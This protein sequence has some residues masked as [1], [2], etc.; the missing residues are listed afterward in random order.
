MVEWAADDP[1]TLDLAETTISVRSVDDAPD[2][3]AEPAQDRQLAG[4]TP[5]ADASA[6]ATDAVSATSDTD[7]EQLLTPENC[8]RAA[9]L[10]L[11]EDP[12]QLSQERRSS[13]PRSSTVPVP[14][15]PWLMLP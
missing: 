2:G 5:T 1:V 7:A 14:T 6:A 3:A 9:V 11:L 15:P 4:N 12:D 13:L 10:A 8:H